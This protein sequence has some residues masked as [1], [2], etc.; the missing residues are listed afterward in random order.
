VAPLKREAVAALVREKIADGTLKP[1]GAAPSG[2]ALARETGYSVATSRAALRSLL[3]DGTLTRGVTPTARLRV[4]QPG[5]DRHPG[6]EALRESLSRTLAARRRAEGLTQPD[7]AA[8]LGV[9]LTMVGH[10]ETG[11]LWQSRDFWWHADALLGG[12]LLRRYDAYQGAQHAA[13][14]EAA[15][16]AEPEEPAPEEPA[17]PPPVLPVSVAITPDGVAVTWPDGTQTL[18]RPLAWLQ[19]GGSS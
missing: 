15:D 18:V 3:R 4:A 7:L 5:A 16:G 12:D 1:G 19:E 11:R 13:A 17:A 14:L 9:S 6:A 8:R 2:L 10:A